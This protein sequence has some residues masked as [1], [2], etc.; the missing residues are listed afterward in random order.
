MGHGGGH[1]QEGAFVQR[2]HEFAAQAGE[3]MGRPDPGRAGADRFGLDAHMPRRGGNE[4]E[5]AIEAQPDA[6]AQHHQHAGNGQE[7]ALWARQKRRI[8]A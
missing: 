1:P 6:G 3:F 4:A 7:E 2:R 5:G 8:G